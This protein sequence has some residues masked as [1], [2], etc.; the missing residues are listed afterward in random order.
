MWKERGED[1]G[2]RAAQVLP[3]V[4]LLGWPAGKAPSAEAAAHL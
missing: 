3:R 2:G 4:W 1:G